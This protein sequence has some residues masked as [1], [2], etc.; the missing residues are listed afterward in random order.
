MI[1]ILLNID[2][3]SKDNL[4][5]RLD[6][7]VMDI[8]YELHLKE[9]VND[10]VYIPHTY[11]KISTR[12]KDLFLTFLKNINISDGYASNISRCINPKEQKFSNLKSHDC[13]ILMQD[14]FLLALR[15]SMAK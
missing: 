14:I 15:S 5:A 3:K 8:R 1:E 12:E 10:K 11:Y 9:L 6:L 4:K 2:R 13:H 7:K